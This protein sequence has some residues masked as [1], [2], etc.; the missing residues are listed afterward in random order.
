MWTSVPW[1][2]AEDDTQ[3][4]LFPAARTSRGA[5]RTPL[6]H[7]MTGAARQIRRQQQIP[8]NQLARVPMVLFEEL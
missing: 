2:V 1:T 8:I 3:G 7:A 4:C 5:R 6:T